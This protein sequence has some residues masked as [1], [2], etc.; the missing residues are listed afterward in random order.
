MPA[1]HSLNAAKCILLQCTLGLGEIL[2]WCIQRLDVSC[3]NAHAQRGSS[4]GIKDGMWYGAYIIIKTA[5]RSFNQDQGPT[6]LG[7]VHAQAET[8][9]APRSSLA[10]QTRR[11]ERKYDHPHFTGMVCGPDGFSD[12]PGAT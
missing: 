10:E 9:P 1:R 12:L 3:F 8:V 7:A 11:G 2:A 4:L 5:P 6:V